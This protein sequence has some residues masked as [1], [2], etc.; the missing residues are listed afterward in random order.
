MVERWFYLPLH[1]EGVSQVPLLLLF[2][3]VHLK[4]LLA[5]LTRLDM[6]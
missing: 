4:R 1:A 3:P 6:K 2:L 5:D